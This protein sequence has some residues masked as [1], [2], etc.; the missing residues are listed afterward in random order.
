MSL[1]DTIAQLLAAQLAPL[2]ESNRRMAAE[3][4]AVRQALPAQLVTIPEAARALRVSVPTVKRRIKDGTIPVRR[5]GHSVR[6]NL[7]EAQHG[8][9]R[10]AIE[11]GLRQIP[12]PG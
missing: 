11:R 6:V 10:E 4:A 2:I 7:T 8:P 3:I 1:E 9:A 12:D 5:F